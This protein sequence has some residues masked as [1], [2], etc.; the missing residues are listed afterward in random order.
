MRSRG[1]GSLPGRKGT[2]W[3]SNPACPGISEPEGC[4]T[5]TGMGARNGC[6]EMG[7]RKWVPGIV[8][9]QC[10]GMHAGSVFSFK[11]RYIVGSGWSRWPSRPI[12]SLR[13]NGASGFLAHFLCQDINPLAGTRLHMCDKCTSAESYEIGL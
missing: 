2:R 11:L 1:P 13:Y 7:A 3:R 8:R 12:R 9:S 5:V 4:V 6:Q 10:V